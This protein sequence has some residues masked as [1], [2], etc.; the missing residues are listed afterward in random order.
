MKIIVCRVSMG[1]CVTERTYV[2]TAFSSDYIEECM[3]SV[4]RLIV[5][6]SKRRAP[7]LAHDHVPSV[8]FSF[9]LICTLTTGKYEG[10]IH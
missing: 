8:V 9:N 5:L 10:D 4:A 3:R 7:R 2:S 6:T 1:Y